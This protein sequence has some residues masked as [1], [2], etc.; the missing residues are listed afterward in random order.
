MT[1]AKP[2]AAGQR[3]TTASKSRQMP[4]FT[5]PPAR[6]VETFQRAVADLPDVQPRQMFGYPAAFTNTQMFASLFQ[7]DL[8]VRL[9]E[10]DREALG[11]KGAHQFE[12]M[13]GRPMREYV[14][15]PQAIRDSP[16]SL[17]SWLEKARAYA[18]SLPPKKK[19]KR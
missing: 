6:L 16:S 1:K 15:V 17:R 3:K 19:K 5:K 10:R 2:K 11:R 13:P 12:P 7:D 8:I 18:A 9:A 4:A 14:V